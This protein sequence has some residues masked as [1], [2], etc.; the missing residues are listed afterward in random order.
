MKVVL[1]VLKNI[2]KNVFVPKIYWLHTNH[3]FFYFTNN[4]I[5]CVLSTWTSQTLVGS[6]GNF[7]TD[8]WIIASFV[9]SCQF[10]WLFPS[11]GITMVMYIHKMVSSKDQNQLSRRRDWVVS[12]TNPQPACQR[13]SKGSP[14]IM[15]TYQSCNHWEKTKLRWQPCNVSRPPDLVWKL[16]IWMSG[17]HLLYLKTNSLFLRTTSLRLYN[18]NHIS[19]LKIKL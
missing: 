12:T 16:T 4:F 15:L 1:K 9:R 5:M 17:N 13:E 14:W 7:K 6:Y 19:F 18:F 3:G 8:L 2:T 11:L 10:C